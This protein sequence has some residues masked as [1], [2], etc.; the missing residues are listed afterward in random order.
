MVRREQQT[1][2]VALLAC[3]GC[4]LL[5]SGPDGPLLQVQMDSATFTRA[6]D[7]GRAQVSFSIENVGDASA[8][9]RGCRD[10][11][12]L[13][14]ER[15]AQTWEEA[16]NVNTLCLAIYSFADQVLEPGHQYRYVIASDQTGTYRLGVWYGVSPVDPYERTVTGTGFTVN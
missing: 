16:W 4:S 7:I 10:P 6:G 1:I 2:T 3:A 9:L 14:V 12:S 8:Y 15:R 5:G 11:I 13:Y